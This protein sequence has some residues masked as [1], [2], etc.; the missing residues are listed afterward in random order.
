MVTTLE[1]QLLVRLPTIET[2]TPLE[3]LGDCGKPIAPANGIGEVAA[4]HASIISMRSS[5]RS[6]RGGGGIVVLGSQNITA[7]CE[8][9]REGW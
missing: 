7:P 2:A 5:R 9:K 3:R 6:H 4:R 8:A 1:G